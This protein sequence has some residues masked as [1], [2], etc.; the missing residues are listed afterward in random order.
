MTFNRQGNTNGNPDPIALIGVG[1]TLPG[2]I[3]N[4]EELLAALRE[5]R[6]LITDIPRDRWSLDA[7]YDADALAPGKT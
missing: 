3:T 1:C 2:K 6:D 5:G 4:K 7:Y